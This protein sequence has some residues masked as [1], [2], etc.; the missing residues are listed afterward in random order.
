MIIRELFI[1]KE[2]FIHGEWI[3]RIKQVKFFQIKLKVLSKINLS[4]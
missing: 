2:I 1:S 4:I 3:I